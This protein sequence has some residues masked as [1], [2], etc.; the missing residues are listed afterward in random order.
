MMASVRLRGPRGPAWIRSCLHPARLRDAA[1]LARLSVRSRIFLTFSIIL[2]GLLV[3]AGINQS[4]LQGLSRAVSSIEQAVEGA[5][6]TGDLALEVQKADRAILAYA[7][8]R[9]S[10]V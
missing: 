10:V 8:D 3:M 7:R 6:L 4:L 5:M 2:G 1:P 9:K